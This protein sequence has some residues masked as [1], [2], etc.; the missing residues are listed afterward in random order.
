MR[1]EG[2]TIIPCKTVLQ[3]TQVSID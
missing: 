1:Y 2:K 3:L